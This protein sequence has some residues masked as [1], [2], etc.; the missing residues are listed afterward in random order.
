MNSGFIKFYQDCGIQREISEP[1]TP[2][3]NIIEEKIILSLKWSCNV[4]KFQILSKSMWWS[5]DGNLLH[6]ESSSSKETKHYSI[7]NME[8][9][10]P[11]R[12]Y[13]KT[14]GCL[15]KVKLLHEH[16]SKVGPIELIVYLLD[17]QWQ[18]NLIDF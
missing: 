9:K 16:T 15:T 5:F 14:W 13:F 17:T 2:Q 11:N 1:Y 18:E 10:K 3:Q 12:S 6:T 8:R 4:D 7:S